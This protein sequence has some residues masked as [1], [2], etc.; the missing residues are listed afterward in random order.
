MHPNSRSL[1][2]I[3]MNLIFYPVNI[4]KIYNSK[5]SIIAGT[6]SSISPKAHMCKNIQTT[7]MHYKFL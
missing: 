3:L 5:V 7:F 4:T 2:N 1:Q 6:N